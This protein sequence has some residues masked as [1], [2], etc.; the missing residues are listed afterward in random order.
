VHLRTRSHSFVTEGGVL[1]RPRCRPSSNAQPHSS[2][3]AG[4]AAPADPRTTSGFVFNRCSPTR[5]STVIHR[6]TVRS[7]D[8]FQDSSASDGSQRLTRAVLW[9]QRAFAGRPSPCRFFPTCSSYAIEALHVHGNARGLWLT[10]R[11]LMRCRPFGPSGFDPV[12]ER[13]P[14]KAK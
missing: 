7:D 11:R 13:S 10:T 8:V 9:Y 6:T 2:P 4:V 5:R 1:Y 12:P 3:I 14:L